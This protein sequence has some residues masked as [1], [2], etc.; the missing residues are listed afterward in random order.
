VSEPLFEQ[1]FCVLLGEALTLERVAQGLR[2][3]QVEI[4]GLTHEELFPGVFGSE[5][6]ETAEL[7][8]RALVLE[9]RWLSVPYLRWAGSRVVIDVVNEAWHDAFGEPEKDAR[10]YLAW[11]FGAHG[12]HCHPGV[13]ERALKQTPE[14]RRD[15]RQAQ[16]HVG[17]IRVRL[18]KPSWGEG[19]DDESSRDRFGELSFLSWMV[20]TLLDL[21]GAVA[22]FNPAAEMLLERESM[23]R[24]LE[25]AR[26]RERQPLSIWLNRREQKL[27]NH[28]WLIDTVGNSQ[29]GHPDLEAF[30]QNEQA[31]PGMSGFLFDVATHLCANGRQLTDDDM[32]TDAVGNA[33]QASNHESSLGMPT[34]RVVTFKVAGTREVPAEHRLR[35]LIE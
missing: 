34:R 25:H 13:M 17:Y 6:A 20:V 9:E 32:V 23:V 29:L 21:P 26:T 33:W 12:A 30:Y 31:M 14:R 11:T 4:G 7:D 28:W 35:V 1:C 27:A 5:M 10:R 3:Y 24:A 16:K 19:M 18:V 22:C 8:P 15:W 2:G